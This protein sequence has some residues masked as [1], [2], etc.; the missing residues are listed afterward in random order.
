M[1]RPSLGTSRYSG[2]V[3]RRSRKQKSR[4][5]RQ[6]LPKK[7]PEIE[8]KI[9]CISSGGDGVSLASW[10]ECEQEIIAEIHVPN[11][12]PGE[13]VR[14]RP[15]NKIGKRLEANL[16]QIVTPSVER[17]SPKCTSFFSCGGCQ[18]Q[19]MSFDAYINW[20]QQSIIDLLQNCNIKFLEFGGLFTSRNQKRRRANFKFKRTKEKNFIGFYA[21]KS[22]QIIE[23]DKC[24]V[25]SKELLETKELIRDGLNR[26][27][28][29]GITISVNVNHFEN[30]SDVLI[31]P[32]QKLENNAEVELASWASGTSINRLSLIYAGQDE[33]R[34]LCQNS[35]PLLNWGDISISPPPGSFLQPT[36]FGENKLQND[37]FLAHKDATH[38][39]DLF[40]GC[41]T[42]SAKLLSQKIRITAIDNHKKCLD[43]YQSGYRNFAQNNFLKTEIHDLIKA[44]VRSE[45]MKNFDGIILDPPRGGAYLQVKQIEQTDCPSVTYVSCNPFSFV[46]DARILLDA[47]YE[48]TKLSILDQF[49]WTAHSELVGN[50]KRL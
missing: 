22:H 40:A 6:G 43:A 15:T 42:L 12:L 33:P 44:P 21:R 30:G 5:N 27:M 10:K 48:L 1:R 31:I 37:V 49:S 8:V 24:A 41:G 13:V 29:I 39:M 4:S 14:I 7:A 47:G 20:K 25:L 11:T 28:P 45:F 2:R 19:H 35:T 17:Q 32:E 3:R 16:S 46:K 38:C 18:L 36:L 23:L 26:I 34:L 9:D 50:F